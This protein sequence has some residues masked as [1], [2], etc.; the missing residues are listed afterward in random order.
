MGSG[1][2]VRTTSLA[3]LTH[4]RPDDFLTSAPLNRSR[5]IRSPLH[6]LAPRIRLSLDQ[7]NLLTV[8]SLR[9]MKVRPQHSYSTPSLVII[10]VIV[11][12]YGLFYELSPGSIHGA[13]ERL[14]A[15]AP[16]VIVLVLTTSHTDASPTTKPW[17]EG[18]FLNFS[19]RSIFRRLLRHIVPVWIWH[20][21]PHL[22]FISCAGRLP[23]SRV[24]HLPSRWL[25]CDLGSHSPGSR[26]HTG[27]GEAA[28][29]SCRRRRGP[30]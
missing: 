3:V 12:T 9:M 13:R 19:L 7:E 5:S 14:E 11:I 8:P 6:Q 18:D 28:A 10:S 26:K 4:R 2:W 30:P 23:A 17:W 21:R 24:P 1:K 27:H 20:F 15:T 22:C 29:R 25:P 16:S